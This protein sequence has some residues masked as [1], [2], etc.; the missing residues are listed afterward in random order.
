MTRHPLRTALLTSAGLI[1]A[2]FVVIA[3]GQ[4]VVARTLDVSDQMAGIVSGGIGGIA[5]I[6]V[7]CVFALV[8]VGRFVEDGARS[9]TDTVIDIVAQLNALPP[10]PDPPRKT[11]RRRA[12]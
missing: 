12:P 2:G 6:S 8:Q 11:S 3:L 5:L 9:D 10:A 4:R 1:V 7:G